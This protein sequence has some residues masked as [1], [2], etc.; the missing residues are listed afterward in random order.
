M[1]PI[2][3]R[4]GSMSF[5]YLFLL[6][7]ICSFKE[8]S[9]SAYFLVVS[10]G[11]PFN[12]IIL[13]KSIRFEIAFFSSPKYAKRSLSRITSAV[14]SFGTIK[15]PESSRVEEFQTSVSEYLEKL[16]SLVPK[17]K[18]ADVIRLKERFASDFRLVID[19]RI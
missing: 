8:L 9:A 10:I 14:F 4:I 15:K 12:R 16:Y 18:T 2:V 6:S 1:L 17:E 13:R 19:S 7:P 5:S 3:V 11:F